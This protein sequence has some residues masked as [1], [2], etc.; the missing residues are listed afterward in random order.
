MGDE[1]HLTDEQLKKVQYTEYVG[2]GHGAPPAE[3][4]VNGLTQDQ[5]D[6]LPEWRQRQ[7]YYEYSTG[8]D[9]GK[10][11]DPKNALPRGTQPE[12]GEWKAQAKDGYDVDPAELRK[13]ANDMKYKLD[14][15]KRKINQV[16]A[17]NIT[18]KDLGDTKGSDKF[19]EVAT[20]SKTGFQQYISSIET[21][22]NAVI[23]KLRA[24]ADQ[25]ENAHN[26]TSKKV[27]DVDPGSGAP[28]LT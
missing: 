21:A 4:K 20:A 18:T 10:W 26:N 24:T 25:Y 7:L 28:D 9:A 8:A 14:I 13:L 27:G 17:T 22:Y 5:W 12:R 11:D 23:G 1:F 2:G 15:W 16:G 6:D 3:I 19:V